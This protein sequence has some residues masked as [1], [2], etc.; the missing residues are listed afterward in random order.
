MYYNMYNYVMEKCRKRKISESFTYF[1]ANLGKNIGLCI[2][3]SVIYIT[4][5]ILCIKDNKDYLKKKE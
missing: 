4:D 1:G 3:N 5:E 2:E